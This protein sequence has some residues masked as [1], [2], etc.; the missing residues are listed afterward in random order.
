MHLLE[1][2]TLEEVLAWYDSFLLPGSAQQRRLSI[3]VHGHTPGAVVETRNAM[4]P[5]RINSGACEQC[6]S[7]VLWDSPNRYRDAAHN[8]FLPPSYDRFVNLL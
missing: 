6:D 2:L 8:V 1:T 4:C 7:L 5:A 3:W